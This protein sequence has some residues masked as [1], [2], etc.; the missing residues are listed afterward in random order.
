[1]GTIWGNW[2][3]DS[4][5]GPLESVLLHRPGD[6]IGGQ[7]DVNAALMLGPVDPERMRAEHQAL[8]NAYREAGVEVHLLDPTGAVPPNAMF[9]R[10]LFFMTPEGAVLARPASAVR[11]GEERLMAQ[12]LAALGVPILLSVHGTGVFEGADALWVDSE[13]L[14]LTTG[15]R[16]NAAG[17]AQV[18]ELLRRM[19]VEVVRVGLPYGTMH[20]LGTL[21]FAGPGLAVAWPTRVPFDAV[22]TLRRKGYQVIFLP[23]EE[24]ARSG[25]ALN[26]VALGPNRVLMP[27]GCPKTREFYQSFGIS[28]HEVEIGELR[29]AAGAIGCLTG[30]LRRKPV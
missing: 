6:E 2:G 10:D 18:E 27:A 7:D 12:R 30:I 3:V 25:M 17:A 14:L 23:D 19:D 15:L 4:E 5:W 1:M 22:E 9:C 16:T 21:N 28:C 8:E 20:L 29:R 26:F 13:T 11:A 24:E